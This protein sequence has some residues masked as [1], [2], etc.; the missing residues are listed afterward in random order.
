M[1]VADSM[2]HLQA[3]VMRDDGTL[4]FSGMFVLKDLN[5]FLPP[6]VNN[7]KP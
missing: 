4:L 7:D 5:S 6:R 3:E 2:N 1:D